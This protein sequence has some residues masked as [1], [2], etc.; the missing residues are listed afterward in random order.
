VARAIDLLPAR[1]PFRRLRA[2]YD[3]SA[4]AQRETVMQNNRLGEEWFERF[5]LDSEAWRALV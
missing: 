2:L 3:P 4:G 1:R 5:A